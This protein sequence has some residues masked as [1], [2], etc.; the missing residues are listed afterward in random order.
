MQTTSQRVKEEPRSFTSVDELVDYMQSLGERT[1][2]ENSGMTE[3]D[4]GLQCAAELASL[5]PD[6]IELHV[7]GLLHDIAHRM[8]H[9]PGGPLHGVIG[10]E[11]VIDLLGPRVAELVESHV[12]AKRYLVTKDEAYRSVLSPISIRTL[13][14]QGGLMTDDEVDDFERTAHWRDALKL[15]RADDAAKTPGRIVPDLDSWIPAIDAVV[16]HYR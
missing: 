13:E 12:P 4:H 3:L 16:E 11:A 1:S 14:A 5:V 7:A 9:V 2:S 10:G 8:D 6:D 15:R